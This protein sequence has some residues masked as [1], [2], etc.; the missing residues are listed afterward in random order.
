MKSAKGGRKMKRYMGVFLIC[1]MLFMTGC[2]G[3]PIKTAAAV[4]RYREGC[5]AYRRG[6]YKDAVEAFHDAVA[7]D[8]SG[9][10]SV[11]AYSY[12]GHCMMEQEDAVAA[13]TYYE[14][15]LSTGAEQAMCYT[16]LGVYYRN[17]EQYELAEQCYRNALEYD[18]GYGD[19]W[20]SL[21]VLYVLTEREEE[22]IEV[23][24]RA[25][26]TSNEYSAV[27]DANLAYAYASVGR[28]HEARNRL[29]VADAKGYPEES[30]TL[31]RAF[32]EEC[33]GKDMPT[34]K[35]E[36]T[37][38]SQPTE[39]PEVTAAPKLTEVPETTVI[40]TPTETPEP[41]VAPVSTPTPVIEKQIVIVI[42]PGHQ[43][44]GNYGKEPVGPGATE[45]KTKVSS[46]TQGVFSKV[47]EHV[48]TLALSMQ[49][50]A[51]LVELG[52]EVI[53]TRE[54]AEVDISNVE[55][56]EVANA[57]GADIYIRIHADGSDNE[58]ANGISV[59]YPSENNPYVAELSK[60]SKRLAQAV[61]DEMCEATDAK[62]RGI[63]KRDDLSGTNWAQMPV[64]LIEAGF[65]TNKAE[66]K[67]LQDPEYQAKLVW[68]IVKG[69]EEYFGE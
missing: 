55:R 65:M 59:L 44:K 56:A 5:E 68:G 35:S 21:G 6:E 34:W 11:Y 19:A 22:A 20:T 16:N 38:T 69:I 62:K 9:E 28:I 32:I 27:Y 10:L 58:T 50:R 30:S 52:Y 2:N 17:C 14:M 67:K 41:T 25:L 66:D 45:Q 39:L 37:A 13:R 42:D 64:I 15:A 60:E 63:V 12:L 47:P 48:F 57:A 40:P 61:L 18:A 51:S 36:L 23:L 7:R 46:G 49:L 24:E 43:A 33:E 31:V 26:R 29:T 4:S 8:G 54:T 3:N 1:C 53:M